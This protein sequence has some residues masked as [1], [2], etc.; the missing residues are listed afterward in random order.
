MA[1]TRNFQ[2]ITNRVL[3]IRPRAFGFNPQTA[4]DNA[5]QKDPAYSPVS[6]VLTDST[7]IQSQAIAQFKSLVNLLTSNGIDVNEESDKEEPKSPDAVFPN[8]WIS[9]HSPLST[10][11]RPV[12]VLYPMMSEI[13]RQERQEDLVK[14]WKDILGADLIDMSHHETTSGYFLEGTGSMVLDR[15]KRIAYATISSRTHPDLVEE[16]CQQMNYKPM[17][18]RATQKSSR[19]DYVPIYHTNVMMCIGEEFAIV[20][21]EA[22]RDSSERE[23]VVKSLEDSGRAL[24]PITEIQ[25]NCYLGNALEL[26][27]K[28]S[29]RFL[30]MSSGAYFSLETWQKEIILKSS[31]IIHCPIN[32]IEILGGGGVRC[33]LAEIFPPK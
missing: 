14:R 22:I 3:M 8:N 1:A 28:E 9:F 12:V 6:S 19:G 26:C 15:V 31:E 2:Q 17:I 7:I 29:K 24:V 21:T 16:F 18:F 20:C 30:V 10:S 33:M 11:S 27:N 32:T 25:M 23:K 4:V 5:F 13:R